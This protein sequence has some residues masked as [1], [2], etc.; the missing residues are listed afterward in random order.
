MLQAILDPEAAPPD[1]LETTVRQFCKEFNDCAYEAAW[2]CRLMSAPMD[3]PKASETPPKT[4]PKT[5]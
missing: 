1:G 5:K 3:A 4:P 2:P